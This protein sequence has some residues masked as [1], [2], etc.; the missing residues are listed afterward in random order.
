MEDEYKLQR[1]DM[2]RGEEIIVGE[3]DGAVAMVGRIG[4]QSLHWQ[5]GSEAMMPTSRD[6]R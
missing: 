4:R 2:R 6:E 5:R 1:H 3:S